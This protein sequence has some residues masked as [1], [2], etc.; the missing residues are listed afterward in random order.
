MVIDDGPTQGPWMSSRSTYVHYGRT[1]PQK[2]FQWINYCP[3]GFIMWVG[4]KNN[5]AMPN[6]I[7]QSTLNSASI[8]FEVIDQFPVTSF[9]ES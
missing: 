4:A 2:S 7:T 8:H 5:F 1:E 9:N 6:F 3:L